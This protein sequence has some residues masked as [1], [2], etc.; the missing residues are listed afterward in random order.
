MRIPYLLPNYDLCGRKYIDPFELNEDFDEKE[1]YK[2]AYRQNIVVVDEKGVFDRWVLVEGIISSVVNFN[3]SKS[4]TKNQ[5]K[6]GTD[7]KPK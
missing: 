1:W 5:E 3:R 6:A 2:R 4:A 7:M